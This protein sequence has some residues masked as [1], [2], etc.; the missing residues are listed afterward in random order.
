MMTLNMKE[1]GL[2]VSKISW[3]DESKDGPFKHYLEWCFGKKLEPDD[4]PGF[5][6]EVRNMSFEELGKELDNLWLHLNALMQDVTT[7]YNKITKL[8]KEFNEQY[9][10]ENITSTPY[11]F[12]SMLDEDEDGHP[13]ERRNKR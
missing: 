13:Y 11:E 3:Y 4:E 12:E 5:Y 7:T 1:G 10:E 9:R 6:R 2:G 8:I